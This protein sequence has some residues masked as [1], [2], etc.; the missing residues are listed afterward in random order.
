MK[1]LHRYPVLILDAHLRHSIPVIRSLGKK[2]IKVIAASHHKLMPAALSRYCAQSEILSSDP[3]EIVEQVND[4]VEKHAIKVIIPCGLNSNLLICQNKTSINPNVFCPYNPPEIF[5]TLSNKAKTGQLSLNLGIPTPRTFTIQDPKMI[6]TIEQAIKFPVVFKS[7]VDQGTVKYAR[8]HEQLKTL[9]SSFWSS[10]SDLVKKG[11]FPIIQE[12]I[13]GDGYGFF[14]LCQNGTIRSFFM[15][16][17]LHEVP[18]SGGPSAMAISYFDETILELGSKILNHCE[19]NGVAM[20]E[21]KKSIIDDK[22]YL[23]EVNPKFWGSL[24]L[25]ITAG[26]DF[27]FDLYCMLSNQKITAVPGDYRR[28][29][30]F[31]WIS[32]DLSYSVSAR[33]L[34]RFLKD[35]FNKKIFSD[36]DWND[37][38]PFIALFLSRI[39]RH[40]K[41]NRH[42]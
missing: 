22:Y 14:A 32:M 28:D 30:I 37:P 17:R 39:R 42:A 3:T 35:F 7:V 1:N 11:Y 13:S 24:D 15:H 34:L 36:W 6:E 21:F 2:G 4:L 27:P 26:V 8:S 33:K 9:V 40:Q 16:K 5:E 31:R 10:N 23:L 41:R 29:I 20:V 25:A 19:W 38:I 18:P 12:H